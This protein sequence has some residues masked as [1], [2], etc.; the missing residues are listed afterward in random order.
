MTE[1][2]VKL[3]TPVYLKSFE[4]SQMLPIEAAA[5]AVSRG[6]RDYKAAQEKQAEW[7]KRWPAAANYSGSVRHARIML[8]QRMLRL[9][10]E[11]E[12]IAK[13]IQS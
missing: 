12:T 3:R 1:R 9:K 4:D 8:E 13:E 11:L 5:R 7:A 10:R 2:D 6:L